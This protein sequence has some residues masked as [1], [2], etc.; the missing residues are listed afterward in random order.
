MPVIKKCH[1]FLLNV[2]DVIDIKTIEESKL[3]SKPN[4]DCIIC[5]GQAIIKN[6]KIMPNLNPKFFFININPDIMAI[7]LNNMPW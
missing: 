6:I 5:H 7:I 1:H 3:Q 4:L 2:N